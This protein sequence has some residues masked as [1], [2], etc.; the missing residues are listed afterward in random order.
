L[1]LLQNSKLRTHNSAYGRRDE[2]KILG[3]KELT[4]QKPQRLSTL[5]SRK[6][7]NHTSGRSRGLGTRCVDA[8]GTTYANVH[9]GAHPAAVDP[10]A[11]RA[12]PL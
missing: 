10:R 2:N 5:A 12:D 7:P 1:V 4:Q 11:D 8:A 9:S 6:K 3:H